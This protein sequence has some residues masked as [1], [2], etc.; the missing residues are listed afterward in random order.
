M[1]GNQ[2]IVTDGSTAFERTTGEPA[3]K[4]GHRVE[5]CCTCGRLRGFAFAAI[6]KG[7]ALLVGR[8]GGEAEAS[9]VGADV[10]AAAK[11]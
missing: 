4:H 2:V 5:I 7:A 10:A 9:A 3:R 11:T 8:K 6:S 1:K